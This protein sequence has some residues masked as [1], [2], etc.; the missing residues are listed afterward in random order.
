MQETASVA[1]RELDAGDRRSLL[2][3]VALWMMEQRAREI[4]ADELRRQLRERFA[5]ILGDE[6][7]ADK[8]AADFLR[9]INERSGLLAERG[10]G[11]YAFSH[12][13]FQ[14]HLA[15]RAVASRRDYIAFALAR[16]GDSWWR[17]TILLEAGYLSTQ[18]TQRV[19]ALVQAIMNHKA[20]PEPYHNLVLAAE[21]LRDI[22][23]ARVEGDLWGEVQR[24][25]RREFERPLR[26]SPWLK[27]IGRQSDI[28]RRRA[29]A[30]EALG[31]IES[32]GSGMQPAFWRL[33]FD[34]PV[35]VAIPEGPFWMG[36]DHITDDE[37]PVH[38]V[39]LASYEIARVPI[40]NAQYLLFVQATKRQ[41]PEHWEDDRPPRGQESHPVVNVTWHD[42]LAYCRW[43]SEATGKAIAL[44]SE[45]QWEKAARGEKDRREYPWGDERDASRCNTRELGIGETT[46]VGIFPEG[47]SPYGCL[48]MIGNVW[49]WTSSL[50]K[51]YPYVQSD[52][53]EN[54]EAGND[55]SRVL[56][57]GSYIDSQYIARCA[58]RDRSSPHSLIRFGGF[59]VV[60]SPISPSALRRSAL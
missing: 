21:C 59:R 49:E 33:P 43:L 14:E 40:T 50:N 23:P 11:S 6:E 20:E 10:Q 58:F 54:I 35:W 12:L 37:K 24:Q 29:A 16:M 34:E 32:G 41:A 18:G 52:D 42:A 46:P 19:T 4:E 45:A 38:Q 17:E 31:R 1:G 26:K 36:S 47:S 57:G 7:Q 13:T 56:R 15:A 27:L 55:A 9:L 53:R 25:L 28:V 48:D 2:E 60:V 39:H 8:A 44:P 3:P 51:P 30:A 22:G 5:T